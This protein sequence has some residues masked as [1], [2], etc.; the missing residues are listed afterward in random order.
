MRISEV[1]QPTNEGVNDP[2]IFKAV[3]MAGAPGAGKST[4]SRML[5]G[6]TGLKQL[7]V[8]NFWALYN[9]TGRS[10]DYDKF[11]KH[12]QNQEKGLVAGRLGLIIDGTAKNPKVIEEIKTR[13]ESHGYETMMVFVDVSLETSLKRAEARAA[14]RNS[15]DFGRTIDPEF[16]KTTY[17]RIQDGADQLRSL[18][19][20]NFFT[21]SNEADS[22][23][24][25]RVERQIRRWINTPVRN[26]IAQ[27]WID[28]QK[29][30]SRSRVQPRTHTPSEPPKSVPPDQEPNS[31]EKA[32]T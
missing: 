13:L 18:F 21:V 29:N 9:K 32:R 8:D 25:A 5:F 6:N 20:N 19:G 23:N 15:P 11:W 26:E 3:F 14:D 22:P 12:Y 10:G 2:N 30:M 17:K 28:N 24:T 1:T 27:A 31:Q 7:N 4:V 16:I